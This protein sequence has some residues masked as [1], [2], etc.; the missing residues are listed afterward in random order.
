MVL[1]FLLHL[2]SR[3]HELD[4]ENSFLVINFVKLIHTEIER[5]REQKQYFRI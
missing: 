4:H 1:Y 5:V 3:D 2:L